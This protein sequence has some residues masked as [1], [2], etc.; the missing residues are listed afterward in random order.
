MMLIQLIKKIPPLRVKV[1]RRAI[2][3]MDK[4][5]PL[6]AYLLGDL[7]ANSLANCLPIRLT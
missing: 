1:K 4:I 2:H 3:V 5:I 7:F 6:E